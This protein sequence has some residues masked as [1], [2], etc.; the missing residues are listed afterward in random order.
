MA[1]LYNPAIPLVDIYPEELKARSQ[2]DV[3]IPT[4]RAASCIIT[5][6]RK[7][8]RYPSIAEWTKECGLFIQWNVIHP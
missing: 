4:L 3:C 1:L 8:L 6:R 5:K 7:Q 2:T